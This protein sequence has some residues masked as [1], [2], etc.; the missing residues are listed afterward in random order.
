MQRAI[1]SKGH[2]LLSN[3]EPL[4]LAGDDAALTIGGGP[5][6]IRA[7]AGTRPV[8]EVDVGAKPWLTTR[9]DTPLSITGVTI[10]ARY[11]GKP[12]KV[13]A[14]IEAAA[15]VALDRCAF[16]AQ[17]LVAG[18]RAVAAEGSSLMVDGC[19]FEGFT[20]AI[21]VASFAG[22]ASTIKQ[23]M[24]VRGDAGADAHADSGGWAVRV[25][26]TPGGNPSQRRRLLLDHCTAQG[27]GLLELVD[28]SPE[29]ALQVDVK[30]C[31]VLA[32]ALVAWKNP[33]PEIPL[34]P[35]ALDW[36]GEGNLYDIRGRSW[37]VTGTEGTPDPK[38]APIDLAS[39]RSKAAEHDPIPPPIRL[40]TP[41]ESLKG[42]PQP[43]DFAV[44]E[45]EVRPPGADP[46]RV[47]PAA[48]AQK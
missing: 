43:D 46:A 37:V 25:R 28:F 38:D 10:V 4:K 36:R 1:G 22:S 17:G 21:D 30:E 23:S 47:G 44:A 3:R 2:V 27:D 26:R 45:P 8:L 19:W 16:R 31:A 9:T 24:M 11:R 5:L 41:P 29:A 34:T 42:P 20:T 35:E 7:A 39:W 33:K 32:D 18:S 6:H 15:S 12:K 14:V 40:R 48:V 13:Q